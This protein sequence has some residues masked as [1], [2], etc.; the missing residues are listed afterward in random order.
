MDDGANAGS[1]ERGK[2]ASGMTNRNVASEGPAAEE[3]LLRSDADGIGLGYA[4]VAGATGLQPARVM[5]IAARLRREGHAM[6]RRPWV[7]CDEAAPTPP[8]ALPPA[9]MKDIEDDGRPHSALSDALRRR[10]LQLGLPTLATRLAAM[11]R[12]ELLAALGRHRAPIR[13][14]PPPPPGAGPKATAEALALHVV[15]RDPIDGEPVGLAY[16]RIVELVREAHPGARTGKSSV[17]W[18][19]AR[20]REVGE[21]PP[22]RRQPGRIQSA[23]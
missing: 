16:G 3:L 14:A 17:V 13:L 22:M 11:T 12:R 18:W 1:R 20:L 2:R 23:R 15:C 9:G 6:P 10:R 19:A 8:P 21:R 5:G 7:L 4:E